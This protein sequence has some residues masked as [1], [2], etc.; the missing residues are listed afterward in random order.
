MTTVNR[1]FCDLC[2][3]ERKVYNLVNLR[4][5][6]SGYSAGEPQIFI[7]ICTECAERKKKYRDEIHTIHLGRP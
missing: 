5:I 6:T 7:D 1:T 3:E 4:A 2:G